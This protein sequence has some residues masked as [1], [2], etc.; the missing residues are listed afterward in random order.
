MILKFCVVWVLRPLSPLTGIVVNLT[1]IFNKMS[2]KSF[3]VSFWN[4]SR[5]LADETHPVRF[6]LPVKK[7]DIIMQ[8]P[9]GTHS[10][11]L[12]CSIDWNI[13]YLDCLGAWQLMMTV[14]KHPKRK[15]RVALE[16]ISRLNLFNSVLPTVLII[17]SWGF[18][19]FSAPLHFFM[20]L[21]FVYWK[22]FNIKK[23]GKMSES[24]EFA[25]KTLFQYF[26]ERISDSG[27]SFFINFTQIANFDS[28]L[29]N[30]RFGAFYLIS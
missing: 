2:K 25:F 13:H 15:V 12:V 24:L 11:C 30:L 5:L 9:L 23:N 16:G 1:C 28:Q 29:N 21:F 20:K 22:T 6:C 8:Q 19:A 14:H 4:G 10:D 27:P 18:D 7:L 3:F 17:Y 26:T